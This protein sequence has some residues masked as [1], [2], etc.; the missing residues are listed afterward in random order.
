MADMLKFRKG[1]YAQINAA[2][3]AAGT[4]YIAKDEKAM[5]VDIDASTR[6]R[7]GDFIRVASIDD[8][9]QPYSETA[10]YYVENANA[11]LG[12]KDGTWKQINGTEEL[13]TRI[14]N[15]E[16]TIGEHSTDIANLKAAIGMGEDGNVEGLGGRVTTLENTVGDSTKGLVKTSADHTA[17]L[18]KLNGASTVAGS[19]AEAKKAG[20]DAQAAANQAATAAAGAQAAADAA[21]ATADSKVTMAQVEAKNY[22]TK[23]DAQGYAN[24]VQGATTKTVAEAVSAAS[25]AQKSADDAGVA[26][27]AAQAKADS[28]YTLAEGKTTMAEV[29]EK[30]YATEAVAEGFAK[31]VQGSTDKTVKDALDAAAA[32]DTKAGNAATAAAGAQTKAD[33]AYDLAAGKATLDEVKGLNY[34]TKSEAEGYA[35]A[36]Q[37]ATEHT[38]ADAMAAASAADTKAGNAATA[39]SGAQSTADQAVLDAAAALAEAQKK[40]TMAAVEAKGYAL[41]AD[42]QQYAKN[43]QG[44][45]DKTVKDALDAAS[46]ADT[47]AAGAATAAQNAQ[48]AAE[49]RVLTTDFNSFKES[50]TVAI[51]DAKKAGTDAAIAAGN[52]QT[53]A[54]EAKT[55][56]ATNATAINGVDARVAAIEEDYLVAKDLADAKAAL[57]AKIESEIDAANSMTYIGGVASVSD[58]PATA[59]IGDT[60]VLTASSG[61]NFAGDLFIATAKEGY[62]EDAETGL[63]PAD[64]IL[65]TRVQTG[66][67]ASL[68]QKIETVDGKIQLSSLTGGDNGSIEF[69][70]TG[71]ATVSV[72]DNVVTVG[73]A[74]EDFSNT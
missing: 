37:G 36:V 17:E 18:E 8:I 24:A 10:V 74:W 66:Y 70:S 19:V 33:Q 46:A 67:D 16:T 50:N 43:V 39:A 34:A 20:T 11:L 53:T 1:T 51:A 54:N 63:L 45:T 9:P 64:G 40:T 48:T 62:K 49:A 73:M 13:V 30:G 15:V 6:I 31:A 61:G 27:S 7:I 4:I 12:Y 25:A 71:S 14:T 56:A 23:D 72:A 42:A 41:D 21:Q 59:P 47:K 28:A 2:P 57:E 26:A 58:L 68:E 55:A 60:Y 65:W 35:S 32:A 5:Y 52:A 3:K 44:N 69:A 29:E 22:A 38:V